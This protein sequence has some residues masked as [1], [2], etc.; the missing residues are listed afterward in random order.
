MRAHSYFKFA[1]RFL[2]I[3]LTYAAGSVVQA[4]VEFY[5]PTTFTLA[6]WQPVRA[7]QQNSPVN[8]SGGNAT[9]FSAQYSGFS[10]AEEAAMDHALNL[11][12]QLIF[13]T[14]P[15]TLEVFSSALGGGVLASTSPVMVSG[16]TG[17]PQPN[18]GYS[19]AF[20]NNQIDCDL[21]P[22]QSDMIIRLDNTISWY[23]GTDQNP[24]PGEYDMV[25]LFLHEMLVGL[26]LL[27]SG[28][29]DNGVAPNECLG[30]A[31]TGCLNSNPFAYDR[32]IQTGIGLP[33]TF[34]TNYSAGLGSAF[35][36]DDLF[37]NGANGVAA[38]GSTPK[39]SAVNPFIA[40]G[41]LSNLDE[42]T[43]PAG[44]A[45]SIFT[46]IFNVGEAQHTIGAVVLG[47]LEDIGWNVPSAPIAHFT[48]RNRWVTNKSLS[49]SDCSAKAVSWE[50]DFNNDALIDD[51][52]QFPSYTYTAAGTYPVTL[53]INGNPAYSVTYFVEISDPPVIPYYNDFE[54]AGDDGFFPS[55][56]TCSKWE[57]G[58]P[59]TFFFNT[60]GTTSGTD[61][62][63]TNLNSTHSNNTS[64]YL[65]TPP[66]T[67]VGAVGDYF[68]RFNYKWAA[69]PGSGV[70]VHVSTDGGNSWNVLGG[71]QG[72]DPNA[73][74]NWY[75]TASIAAL[76]NEPGWVQ[77]T[78]SNVTYP[79]SY[80]INAVAGF[81]DVR[82]RI[83]FG[84][85][86]GF[87]QDGFMVD[88]FEIQGA[89]LPGAA[90]HLKAEPRGRA[91]DLVWET[92]DERA[93][94]RF[95][96]ERSAD[97]DSFMPIGE[98]AA[99]G[100][101]DQGAQYSFTDLQ[102]GLGRQYY[103]IR[104]LSPSGAESTS[105]V[106]SVDLDERPFAALFSALTPAGQPTLEIRQAGARRA[107]FRLQD[108]AGREVY[109]QSLEF[110]GVLRTTLPL[111][112]LAKGLYLYSVKTEQGILSGRWIK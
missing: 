34:I 54:S 43:F 95:V 81:S 107:V 57:K 8:R 36:G 6:D 94:R 75:N 22:T 84:T 99:S 82:F 41:N 103:R 68:L 29:Y 23:T 76:D 106:V 13:N 98:Q 35:I 88:D 93:M 9:V 46:P 80:R 79:V 111:G 50:W 14:Y 58:D 72:V 60:W 28:Q 63:V 64:Y 52:S 104:S 53:T 19:I 66:T 78:F 97:G 5:Y 32:F 59:G 21:D 2:L 100:L 62:W 109:Q 15:I 86:A 61:A 37:W 44:S 40:G 18:T 89:V 101:P 47:M 33:I 30:T 91:V 96:V 70:N 11:L 26:G 42:A 85:G 71:L 51:V 110:D 69:A 65:E 87:A 39:L 1:W 74:A 67:F 12:G 56:L 55:D 90:L 38:L 49:F 73:D 48:V 83:N 105:M 102:A 4:Q 3:A 20:A 108:L 10:A 45:N 25:T 112:H 27:S 24:G 16:F 77:P 17:A 92:T 31:G 7:P